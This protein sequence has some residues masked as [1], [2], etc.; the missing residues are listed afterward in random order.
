MASY[1]RSKIKTLLRQSDNALSPDEKG[2]KF[3]NLMIYVF[4]KVPGVSFYGRNIFDD[5]RAEEI[6]LAFWNPQNRSELCFLDAVLIVECKNTN[7]PVGSKD[8]AWF[9]TKLRGRG[10]GCGVLVSLSGITGSSDGPSNAHSEVLD[11]LKSGIK[12]LLVNRDE[13]LG[14]SQTQ[15]LVAILQEKMLTL[16]LRKAVI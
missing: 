13:I 16:Q 4:S 11:A 15:D 3:E 5:N 2:G 1:S 14:L 7:Q 10:T 8:V 6:D 9:V 12:I